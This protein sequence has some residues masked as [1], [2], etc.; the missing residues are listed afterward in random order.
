MGYDQSYVSGYSLHVLI[1]TYIMRSYI[2]RSYIIPLLA[3]TYDAVLCMGVCNYG[4]IE[5][6]CYPELARL[7]KP[8][9]DCLSSLILSM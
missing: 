8:G 9:K 5:P 4:H 1:I 7:V 6:D 2:M 3:G